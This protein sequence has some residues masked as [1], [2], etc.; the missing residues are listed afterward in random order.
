[1]RRVGDLAS[2]IAK[3]LNR[4]AHKT[5]SHPRTNFAR[6]YPTIFTGKERDE[7]TGYGYFGARYMDHELM[8]MWLSVDPMADKYPSIS[9]Y[10]YCAWNPVKLV[11][12]DGQECADPPFKDNQ[13]KTLI[14]FEGHNAVVRQSDGSSL[15]YDLSDLNQMK[16]FVSTTNEILSSQ[17]T[18]MGIMGLAGENCKATFRLTNSKGQIDLRIYGNGWAGN[19]Y[20]SPKAISKIASRFSYASNVLAGLTTFCSFWEASVTENPLEKTEKIVDGTMGIVS[21]VGGPYGAAASLYYFL[22]LKNYDIISESIKEDAIER[23]DMIQRG[24][25]ALRLGIK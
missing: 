3:K 1:M 5:E 10:A 21:I 25:P 20:V 17:G 2:D 16:S 15:S 8:T 9:P 6:G 12:P 18:I 4:I 14:F 19:Q 24:Y 23:A 11:D 13:I 22:V 7:E